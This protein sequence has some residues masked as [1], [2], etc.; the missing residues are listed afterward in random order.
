MDII[1][2]THTHLENKK[3]STQRVLLRS[4]TFP[5]S[6]KTHTLILGSLLYY[7]GSDTG[8]CRENSRWLCNW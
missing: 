5:S 1:S 7:V 6:G 8:S 3:K 4:K 2:V